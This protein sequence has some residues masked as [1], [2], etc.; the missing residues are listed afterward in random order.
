MNNSV[1]QNAS[2]MRF[3]RDYM[4]IPLFDRNALVTLSHEYFSCLII[5]VV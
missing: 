5:S 4:R 3:D 2:L 1:K